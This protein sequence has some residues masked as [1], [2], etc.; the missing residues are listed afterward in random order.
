MIPRPSFRITPIAAVAVVAGAYLIRSVVIRSGDFSLDLP[1]DVMAVSL[2]AV[3]LLL[4]AMTRARAV[5]DPDE[6]LDTQHHDEHDA[7]RS[8]GEGEGL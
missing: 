6:R 2:L 3:A 4:A 8:H 1:E 7:P 5:N